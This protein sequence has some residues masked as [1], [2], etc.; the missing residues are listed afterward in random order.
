MIRLKALQDEL[1]AAHHPQDRV[2]LRSALVTMHG[3]QL[4]GPTS[5]TV[6]TLVES[7]LLGMQ[8]CHAALWLLQGEAAWE[9]QVDTDVKTGTVASASVGTM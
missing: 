3:R 8:I 5:C 9:V 4:H 7:M 6:Y 2:R 1:S